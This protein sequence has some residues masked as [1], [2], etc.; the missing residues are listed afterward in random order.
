EARE[1]P[2]GVGRRPRVRPAVDKDEVAGRGDRR[3]TGLRR[4]VTVVPFDQVVD[5]VE[6]PALGTGTP[7]AAEA[8][9]ILAALR[10]QGLPGFG[11]LILVQPDRYLDRPQP[12][13]PRERATEGGELCARV[14]T[15]IAETLPQRLAGEWISL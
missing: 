5:L 15:E 1:D 13:H 2:G 14:R 12:A 6:V 9:R 10:S 11:E 4:V 3:Q 8:W 7:F